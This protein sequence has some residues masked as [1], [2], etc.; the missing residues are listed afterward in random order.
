MS[1]KKSRPSARYAGMTRSEYD[2]EAAR[3][4]PPHEVVG[5]PLTDGQW[6]LMKRGAKAER[7]RRGRPVKPADQKVARVLVSMPRD[8]LAA[9]DAAADQRDV[10]RATLIAHGMRTMLKIRS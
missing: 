5:T 8:L 2:T 4:E 1:T 3:L 6:T 10:T 9:I 7:K